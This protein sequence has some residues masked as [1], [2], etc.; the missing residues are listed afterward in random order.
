MWR[1]NAGNSKGW[2]ENVRINGLWFSIGNLRQQ[3][4]MVRIAGEDYKMKR[5]AAI[6]ALQ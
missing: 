6:K 4:N 3:C 2:G 1:K 5:R